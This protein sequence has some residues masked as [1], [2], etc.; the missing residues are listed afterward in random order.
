[1]AATFNTL[2]ID[3][4]VMKKLSEVVN[5]VPVIAKSDSL[6]LEEREAFKS[7]VGPLRAGQAL[8]ALR[9]GS[10]LTASLSILSRPL[11]QI[12]AELTHHSIRLYP[13]DT[14]EHDAE[15]LALNAR[16]RDMI[17]FAVVGSQENVIVDGKPVRGRRNRYGVVNVEDERHCEFVYLRNFLTRCVPCSRELP[18]GD[19]WHP[20]A[21]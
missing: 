12:R 7:R 6:T 1:L 4:T 15:E 13:Y 20:I 16:I 14:I 3:I 5:V 21:R 10:V 2:Q 8:E 11:P 17:P 9:I 19:D 18:F